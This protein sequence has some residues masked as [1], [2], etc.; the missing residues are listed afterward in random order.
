MITFLSD[1][2]PIRGLVDYYKFLL[3]HS[4]VFSK[5]SEQEMGLLTASFAP[6]I[7]V[8]S[9]ASH[10]ATSS[11]NLVKALKN[12]IA[13]NTRLDTSRHRLLRKTT[14]PRDVGCRFPGRLAR[15]CQL[16]SGNNN[17]F[18]GSTAV[19]RREGKTERGCAQPAT[20][21]SEVVVR[22]DVVS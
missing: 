19:E 14:S 8:A 6:E 22:S 5:S 1:V 10:T 3:Y 15:L 17:A 13:A 11:S 18:E 20:C 12:R 16:P 21:L 4:R 9:A 2:H 7:C